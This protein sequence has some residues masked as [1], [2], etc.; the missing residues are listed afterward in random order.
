MKCTEELLNR[1]AYSAL[2][3]VHCIHTQQ[4]LINLRVSEV[5]LDKYIYGIL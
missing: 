1:A 3:T 2:H 5:I 4:L